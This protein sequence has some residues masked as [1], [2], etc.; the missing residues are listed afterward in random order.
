MSAE[1]PNPRGNVVVWAEANIQ[2]IAMV[3]T[4]GPRRRRKD[5]F[6]L[7]NYL[8]STGESLY[9]PYQ[10]KCGGLMYKWKAETTRKGV[11][12]TAYRQSD[13]RIVLMMV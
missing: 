13:G 12:L 5:P 9:A 1:I 6:M 4:P 10:P 2:E 7:H 3:R 8:A 11:R